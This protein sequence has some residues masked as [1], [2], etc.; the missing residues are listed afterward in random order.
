MVKSDKAKFMVDS[1]SL[2]LF[3][4]DHTAPNFLNAAYRKFYLVRS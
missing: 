3:K 4:A 1:P 2:S